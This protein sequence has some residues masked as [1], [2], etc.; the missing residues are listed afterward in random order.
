MRLKSRTTSFS[1]SLEKSKSIIFG[2]TF[3]PPCQWLAISG[4]EKVL[5]IINNRVTLLLCSCLIEIDNGFMETG[6]GFSRSP[7]LYWPRVPLGGLFISFSAGDIVQKRHT[8]KITVRWIAYTDNWATSK[9]SWNA[10]KILVF[11]GITQQQQTRN[12]RII[13]LLSILYTLIHRSSIGPCKRRVT[14]SKTGTP[15]N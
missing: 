5:S 9:I 13:K 6:T 14:K 15:K 7:H 10:R 1:K 2:W 4:A 3:A 11:L 12:C 8:R